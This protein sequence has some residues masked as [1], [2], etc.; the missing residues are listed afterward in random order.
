MNISNK[1]LIDDKHQLIT[2][3]FAKFLIYGYVQLGNIVDDIKNIICLYFGVD[4]LLYTQIY[5]IKGSHKG[6][7]PSLNK[8]KCINLN[9][10]SSYNIN[11]Y[12]TNKYQHDSNDVEEL[13][14]SLAND[15]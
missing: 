9:Y 1:E 7:Q 12:N 2:P 13:P 5:V 4:T 8:I 6:R 10:R 14:P 15:R 11:I 3:E